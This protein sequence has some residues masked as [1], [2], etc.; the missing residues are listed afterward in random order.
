M[1]ECVQY[2]QPSANIYK[3]LPQSQSRS[4]LPWISLWPS[5]SQQSINMVSLLFSHQIP[6]ISLVI[7]P[8]TSGIS[9]QWATYLRT[10][11]EWK[12]DARTAGEGIYFSVSLLF[13]NI[14]IIIEFLC[15][16]IV[17]QISKY[18]S[19]IHAHNDRYLLILIQK[20][21]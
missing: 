19:M 18:L 5:S 3:S 4:Q 2:H 9:V 1:C 8:S 14:Y 21:R 13:R 11:H 17:A 16:L 6:N 12:V 20:Q 7:P 10:N 15:T